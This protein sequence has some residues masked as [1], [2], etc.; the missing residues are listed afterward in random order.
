MRVMGRYSSEMQETRRPR[1]AV[2]NAASEGRLDL[3]DRIV[4]EPRLRDGVASGIFH[5]LTPGMTLTLRDAIVG[6]IVL[7]DNVCTKMVL[8]RLTLESV[9]NYCKAV[10]MTGTHHRFLIPPYGQSV[11]GGPPHTGRHL[12][13]QLP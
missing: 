6:M 9:A 1:L 2:L 7:S 5:Y 12:F 8:E 3:E 11:Q 4:Y 10:G 13:Q